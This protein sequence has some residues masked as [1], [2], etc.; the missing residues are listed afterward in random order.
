VAGI[1]ANRPEL[2]IKVCGVVN[3]SDRA[4]LAIKAT[5]TVVDRPAGQPPGAQPP[6][7]PVRISDE[8]LLDLATR[9]AA[10]VIDY[11]VSKHSI[12]A[13]RLAACQP[14]IDSTPAGKGRVDLL[15]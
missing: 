8:Q 6:V 12:S 2:N 15:I 13:S 3:E 5:A 10:A 1:L 11:L 9:R 14:S 4:T 7:A